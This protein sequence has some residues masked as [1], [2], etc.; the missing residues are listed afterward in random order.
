MKEANIAFMKHFGGGLAPTSP[1]ERNYFRN[2]F[3]SRASRTKRTEVLLAR[4]KKK[5]K[6]RKK[7]PALLVLTN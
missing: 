2:S 3:F 7:K 6:E 4:K 1:F 5:K